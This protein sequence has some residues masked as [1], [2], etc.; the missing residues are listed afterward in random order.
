MATS[1]L[2]L[3]PLSPESRRHIARQFQNHSLAKT[4]TARV[5]GAL[6]GSGTV[7]LPLRCDW[8]NRPR[9]MVDHDQGRPA[10][11]HWKALRTDDTPD[12]PVTRLQLTPVTGRSHQLR[13]HCLHLGHPILGDRIYALDEPYQ[14]AT[15]LQLHAASVSFR[16]PEGGTHTTLEAPCPF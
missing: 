8:P 12:G 4:Y 2:M 5:W 14:A 16:H 13:V 10:I 9:Q 15:R 6:T 1:G 7:D 3:F 11:T